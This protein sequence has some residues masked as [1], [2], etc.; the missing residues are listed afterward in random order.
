MSLKKLKTQ[1]NDLVTPPPIPEQNVI[2]W[3]ITGSESIFNSVGALG[4]PGAKAGQYAFVGADWS[5]T[6]RTLYHSNGTAWVDTGLTKADQEKKLYRIGVIKRIYRVDNGG[7]SELAHVPYSRSSDLGNVS[8][9]VD[10]SD[11]NGYKITMSLT[12]AT[13]ITALPNYCSVN[14]IVAGHQLTFTVARAIMLWDNETD[15]VVGGNV[16]INTGGGGMYS[17]VDFDALPYSITGM[18]ST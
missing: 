12:G 16:I 10:L 9:N 5:A 8:G 2:Y 17:D 18:I 1:F 7:L 15:E 14:V 4:D 6:P 3:L 13:I 11:Y